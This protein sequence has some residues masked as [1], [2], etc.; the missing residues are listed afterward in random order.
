M[1][2]S[3]VLYN[4]Q[5]WTNL[6]TTDLGR[7]E[8]LQLNYLKRILQ[9]PA[10]TP[11]VSVFLELGILPIEAEIHKKQLTFLHHILTLSPDDPVLIAYHEQM[12]FPFEPNWAN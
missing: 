3:S 4:S 11:N 8:I 10:S 2:L 5:S 1:F 7:L 6:S 12:S 9:A